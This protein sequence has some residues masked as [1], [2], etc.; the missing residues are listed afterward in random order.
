MYCEQ[1]RNRN[2]K[3]YTSCIYLPTN[4]NY[5]ICY[6]NLGKTHKCSSLWQKENQ[7]FGG[8]VY[9]L[10]Q[11]LTLFTKMKKYFLVCESRYLQ[12]LLTR[13]FVN[14]LKLVNKVSEAKNI[15]MFLG[16]FSISKSTHL[17][18]LYCKFKVLSHDMKLL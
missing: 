10:Y 5:S 1:A 13:N 6:N 3:L 4:N 18:N 16:S 2:G 17:H 12:K 14:S 9:F 11:V 15:D 7:I 8:S